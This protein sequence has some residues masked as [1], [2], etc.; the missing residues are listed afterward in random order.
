MPDTPIT[1]AIHS[2]HHVHALINAVFTRPA[3]TCTAELEEL[4]AAFADDF[5]MVGVAGA[6]IDR[7]QVEQLF[8]RAA[9]ARPGLQIEV[10][11]FDV[12]WQV[13]AHVALRYREVHRQAGVVTTRWSLALLE[14]DTEAVVWRCL[15]ETA[16][17]H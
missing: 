11:A 9:G 4:L 3:D 12:V 2:V 1:R 8:R 16:T 7:Q 10:D 15:Q 6:L 17:P 14:C 13:G 5:S